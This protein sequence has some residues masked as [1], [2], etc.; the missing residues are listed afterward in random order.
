[1]QT[2]NGFAW[3]QICQFHWITGFIESQFSTSKGTVLDTTVS[4][5]SASNDLNLQ[6]C[7]NLL[8]VTSSQEYRY[9]KLIPEDTK[10]NVTAPIA[11]F[12][13]ALLGVLAQ[14][15]SSTSTRWQ[16]FVDVLMAVIDR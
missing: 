1:V 8:S 13:M 3:L 6:N 4:A 7:H 11:T 2:C 15:H 5:V 14:L 9:Y 16:P 10:A 12:N